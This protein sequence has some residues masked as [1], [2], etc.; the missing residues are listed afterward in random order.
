M[1]AD[2]N[3]DV[4]THTLM[5]LDFTDALI[6]EHLDSQPSSQEAPKFVPRD[7]AEFRKFTRM[8]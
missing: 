2:F 3:D 8:T 4:L 6:Q 7:A 1:K 5:T